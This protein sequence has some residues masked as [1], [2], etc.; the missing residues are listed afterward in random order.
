[1]PIILGN[2]KAFK[3]NSGFS[4]SNTLWTYNYTHTGGL[5][6]VSVALS[7]SGS[8]KPM[9]AKYN[10]EDMD[11][12]GTTSNFASSVQQRNAVYVL[13]DPPLGQY[14]LTIGFNSYVGVPIAVF[15][16]S[17]T[18][19]DVGGSVIN[20]KGPAGKQTQNNMTVEEGSYIYSFAHGSAAIT[21]MEIPLGTPITSSG[22]PPIT[23]MYELNNNSHIRGGLSR[24]PLAAGTYALKHEVKFNWQKVTMNAYEIRA[25]GSTPPTPS[26]TGNFLLLF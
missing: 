2:K 10:G 1:M 8:R 15:I 21:N 18:G 20:N 12:V 5:L 6:L 17:F 3:T 4:D 11:Q 22:T 16:H 26:T 24:G 14:A 13:K 23:E 19:A 9:W 7:R 25:S